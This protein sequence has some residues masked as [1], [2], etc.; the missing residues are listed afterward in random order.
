M[1]KRTLQ[2]DFLTLEYLTHSLRISGLTPKGKTN[3]FADLSHEPPIS[4]PYGDFHFRGGHRLW[5]APESMPRTYAPDTGEL[6]ITELSDGVI[7]ETQTEPG[8]GIRKRIEIRLAPDQPSVTLTHTLINDGLWAV[9]LA[10]WAITQFRLGGTALLPLPVGNVDAAGL[11][12]NRQLSFWSYTRLNDPRLSLRDDFI[13]FH[14]DALPPFKIG[15]FNP[16]GWLAYYVDD[17]LFKKTFGALSN[18]TYPDNNSNAELYCDHRFVEL[19]SLSPLV[20]LEPG[21]ETHHRETWEVF[22]GPESLPS[23]IHKNFHPDKGHN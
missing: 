9:E 1:G 23:D 2:N 6:K 22:E 12:P 20:K 11:L 18:A 13:L 3:L 14:A 17:I 19:E 8:T 4:T 5:H 7:L 16:H 15:Y 21:A 10:P